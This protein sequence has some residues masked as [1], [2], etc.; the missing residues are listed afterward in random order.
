MQQNE[1]D[2][3]NA[4]FWDELCGSAL[5]RSIGITDI[6]PET[7]KKFDQVY[8]EIYPYLPGYVTR[9]NLNDKRVLEVGLGYG[10]LGQFL[11]LQ[12]CEYFGLDIAE[13]PVVVMSDR[14]RFLGIKTKDHVRIGSA[15]DIPFETESFDFVYSV[16]CLHHTGNLA[17]SVEEVYRVLK[18]GGKA[19]IMLYNR[20]SFR[21]LVQIPYQ[22]FQKRLT[23]SGKKNFSEWIRSLYDTNLN[24]EVAPYTDYVSR[25]DVKRLFRKF[26]ALK[27]D[28][29]NF[30]NY[31]LFKLLLIPRTNLLNNLGRIV[32]LDLYIVAQK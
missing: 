11:A 14:L 18:P 9:E 12:G 24:G 4:K 31:V 16:G 26:S 1:I 20:H 6:T 27:I 25:A 28:S 13:G 29:Q 2:A 10:T 15:L 8:M 3:Q 32:G 7:L 23:L 5:A 19:V 21:Q 17:Q 30:D 22:R